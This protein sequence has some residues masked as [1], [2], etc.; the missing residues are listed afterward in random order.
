[1]LFEFFLRD[2]YY[3]RF[4]NCLF[5]CNFAVNCTKNGTIDGAHTIDGKLNSGL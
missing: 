2:F 3:L 4:L 5:Q 1:M